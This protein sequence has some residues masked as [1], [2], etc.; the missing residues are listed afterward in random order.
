LIKQIDK[1]AMRAEYLR[2]K[3]KETYER[4]NEYRLSKAK[5]EVVGEI[6]VMSPT[7]LIE[8]PSNINL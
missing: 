6:N 1:K 5:S 8:K 2:L 4:K 3:R 7:L